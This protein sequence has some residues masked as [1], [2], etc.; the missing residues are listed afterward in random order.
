MVTLD[1]ATYKAG[2]L[3]AV[4][5]RSVC[6]AYSDL[7]KMGCRT[8]YKVRPARVHQQQ[9]VRRVCFSKFVHQ[10]D[11]LRDDGAAVTQQPGIE[12]PNVPTV[13]R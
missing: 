2:K 10:L 6:S 4:L 11:N 13:G 1:G 12:E 9:N 7:H 3:R 8:G 5:V